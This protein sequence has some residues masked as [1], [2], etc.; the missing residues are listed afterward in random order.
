VTA[1]SEAFLR[2]A[3]WE[4]EIPTLLSELGAAAAVSRVY[5]FRHHRNAEGIGLWSQLVEWTADGVPPEI[6]N[7]LFQ[8]FD[9]QSAGFAEWAELLAAREPA[10]G[11]VAR[12]NAGMRAVFEPQHIRSAAVVPVFVQDEWWGMI[13]FDDCET[14]RVWNESELDALQ[15]AADSLGA[16][17]YR[18]RVERDLQTN[19]DFLSSIVHNLGQAVLV[20]DSHGR[21]LFV[22]PAYSA[23][24]GVPMERLIGRRTDEFIDPETMDE[25]YRQRAQRS[26]GKTG[27]YTSRILSVDGSKTDVLV[28]AVPRLVDGQPDGAYCVL[29]DIS[30]RRRLEEHRVQMTLEREQMR[31]MADFVRDASHDFRTPLSIIQTSLY[32]LRR[33]AESAEQLERLNTVGNQASRLSRLID[34]LLTMLELDKAEIALIPINLNIVGQNAVDRSREHAHGLGLSLDLTLPEEPALVSGEEGYL[35][36]AVANLVDNAIAFTPAGGRIKVAIRAED[37]R[38]ALSVSDTGIGIHADEHERI[39]ERLY[40]VDKARTID[41]GGL[42]MGLS[43]TKRIMELHGGDVAVKSAPGEGSTF[44]LTFARARQAAPRQRAPAA[45]SSPIAQDVKR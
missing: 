23:M 10:Y 7:P 18:Q 22:N 1:S 3:D 26:Q 6:D 13:G 15:L 27:I 17:I 40:K 20:V 21:L 44:T 9:Y 38:I 24:T 42:G 32:L 8:N 4:A 43:I 34:G 31:I 2:A 30:E 29:T 45:V 5:A 35:M 37:D 12:M 39:F 28:T 11:I 16:A 36:K 33:K 19:R 14:E 25:F 41:S